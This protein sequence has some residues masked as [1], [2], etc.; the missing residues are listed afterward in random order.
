MRRLKVVV[1]ALVASLVVVP[2]AAQVAAPP[3]PPQAPSAAPAATPMTPGKSAI[4]E[5]VLVRVNGEIFTQ[6]ELERRQIDALRD[7]KREVTDP[8]ALENDA[9]LR[10][11]LADLTPDIL[12]SAVEELLLMQR[13]RELGMTFGDA[14]LTSMLDNI[15]KQN[16]LDDK[17][18]AQAM[19]EAG[20][21]MPLLRQQL[22]RTWMIRGVQQEEIKLNLTEEEARQYYAAHPEEFMKPATVTLREISVTVPTQGKGAQALISVGT[23]NDAKAKIDAARARVLKG[24]DFAVVAGEVSESGSKANG[25]LIGQVQ[26]EQLNPTLREV[27]DKLKPGEVSEPLRTQ[28]GYQ[29]FKVDARTAPEREPFTAVRDDIGARIYEDRVEGETKKLLN[30]LRMQALIEWKDPTYKQM[31]EKKVAEKTAEKNQD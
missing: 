30:R 5:R 7:Q 18:L 9:T 22:E 17:G 6:T 16:N 15:K 24:D 23:D 1:T 26:L 21:T 8:R 12:V 2:V 19:S 20:L 31:Y 10:T 29:M 13:G 28:T 11:I 3:V 25:G 14:Q 4:I 27:L